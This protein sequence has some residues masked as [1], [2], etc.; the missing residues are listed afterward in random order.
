MKGK[1]IVHCCLLAG[2]VI[3]SWYAWTQFDQ[4]QQKREEALED[5]RWAEVEQSGELMET[6][7]GMFKVAI[8]MLAATIYGATLAVMY[9]LPALAGKVS[10][11]MMGSTA[12]L[13]ADPRQDARAAEDD[14]DYT[15][16]IAI[17]RDLLNDNPGDRFSLLEIV[18]IQRKHLQSPALAVDTLDEALKNFDWMPDDRASLMFRMA[19]IYEEDMEDKEKMS[20]VLKRV[21]TE[22]TGTPHA[23]KATH[24]LRELEA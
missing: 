8:P 13:D 3:Y 21:E 1:L 14:E 19:D 5:N 12:E 22:L 20:G 7:K 15:G 18:R 10:E 11:G 9:L 23:G 24:R 6:G 17:Y 16:A 2:L 4:S